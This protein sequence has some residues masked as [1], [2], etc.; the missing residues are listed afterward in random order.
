MYHYPNGYRKH[1]FKHSRESP[2]SHEFIQGMNLTQVNCHPGINYSSNNNDMVSG[3]FFPSA[4]P[5]SKRHE[6]KIPETILRWEPYIAKSMAKQSKQSGDRFYSQGR[7]DGRRYVEVVNSNAY[8]ANFPA[9]PAD[10]IGRTR[11]DLEPR[12]EVKAEEPWITI[13]H[14]AKNHKS[15]FHTHK[16]NRKYNNYYN[17]IKKVNDDNETN[18]YLCKAQV[19]APTVGIPNLF[20]DPMVSQ[21]ES[22][23]TPPYLVS[24]GTAHYEPEIVDSMPQGNVT[25]EVGQSERDAGSTGKC[26]R[27]GRSNDGSI[28]KRSQRPKG[29]CFKEPEP[30]MDEEENFARGMESLF[31]QHHRDMMAARHK[32]LLKLTPKKKSKINIKKMKLRQEPYLF[33][34]RRNRSKNYMTWNERVPFSENFIRATAQVLGT[35]TQNVEDILTNLNKINVIRAAKNMGK[36]KVLAFIGITLASTIQSKSLLIPM[37]LLLVT[38]HLFTREM[39]ASLRKKQ[40]KSN[41]NYKQKRGNEQ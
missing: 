27:K 1:Q 8:E 35:S 2:H 24:A 34:K 16:Y 41:P 33:Q 12:I 23:A 4:M 40:K 19:G 32:E 10:S 15:S 6:A 13:N 5:G 28:P 30:K 3:M 14:K 36:T 31:E 11:M 20:D 18:S 9:L 39:P 7:I 37:L 17:I 29:G 26:G 25:R 38:M 22:A 21:V